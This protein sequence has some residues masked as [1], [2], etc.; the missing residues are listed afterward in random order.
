[1]SVSLERRL[2]AAGVSGQSPCLEQPSAR[3]CQRDLPG[4][5]H[6]GG[7]GETAAPFLM[8]QLI[9]SPGH[10]AARSAVPLARAS[11]SANGQRCCKIALVFG[12]RWDWDAGW[13]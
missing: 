8:V 2:A 12:K 6:A 4:A 7:P 5:I 13:S 10:A 9:S 3:C 11:P 1:M